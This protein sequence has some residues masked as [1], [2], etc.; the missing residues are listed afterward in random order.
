[1]LERSGFP[2]HA[3]A[4]GSS[5]EGA[6]SALVSALRESSVAATDGV[7]VLVSVICCPSYFGNGIMVPTS[8]TT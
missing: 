5:M 6:E 8:Q 4:E 2:S 1:M 7:E 3:A